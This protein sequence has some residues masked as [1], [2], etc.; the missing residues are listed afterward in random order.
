MDSTKEK[1]QRRRDSLGLSEKGVSLI[2]EALSSKGWSR[3]KW[4]EN[5]GISVN[6]YPGLSTVQRLLSGKKID[7][8]NFEALCKVLYPTPNELIA[9]PS[10]QLDSTTPSI[11]L[12]VPPLL[13]PL[14]P[15]R[16]PTQHSGTHFQSF[17]ITGTFSPNKLE[18]IKVTLTHIEK[19]LRNDCTFTLMPDKNYLAVSGKVSEDKKVHFEAA[20]MHLKKLLL[21]HYITPELIE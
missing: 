13:I 6:I 1:K 5:V 8:D 4:I 17:M 14:P 9:R 11:P 19:L 10:D 12:L 18:E 16:S 20:L 3:E 7:R 21:E 2:K 15:E